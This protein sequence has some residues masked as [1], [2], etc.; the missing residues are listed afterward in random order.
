ML[1]VCLLCV[2]LNATVSYVRVDAASFSLTRLPPLA[3][4]RL[5]FTI[6]G[7]LIE[8]LTL[9]ILA[10]F[11]KHNISFSAPKQAISVPLVVDIS[12]SDVHLEGLYIEGMKVKVSDANKLEVS[13]CNVT[14]I[15]PE[16]NYTVTIPKLAIDFIL[17]LFT[18]TTINVKFCCQPSNTD[19]TV[20]VNILSD[21]NNKSNINGRNVFPAR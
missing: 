13:M 17:G 8:R 9:R 19:S 12:T 15:M 16:T 1:A 10:A 6:I 21:T 18:S 14:A 20:I 11:N 2:L 5:N 3:P 4:G 7:P